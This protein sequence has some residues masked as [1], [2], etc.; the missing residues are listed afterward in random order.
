MKTITDRWQCL[1]T[2]DV[3]IRSAQWSLFVGLLRRLA[4]NA[5]S[6]PALGW[7]CSIPETD[8]VAHRLGAS[9]VGNLIGRLNQDIVPN[10][11]SKYDSRLIIL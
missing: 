10:A 9:P 2:A 8:R 3:S 6:F 11:R 7:R 1:F 5:H 4:N